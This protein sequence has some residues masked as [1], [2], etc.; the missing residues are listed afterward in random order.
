MVLEALR[1]DGLHTGGN[2][3]DQHGIGGIRRGRLERVPDRDDPAVDDLHQVDEQ[4]QQGRDGDNHDNA[5]NV[6][7]RPQVVLGGGHGQR[8]HRYPP[9]LARPRCRPPMMM[10]A[11]SIVVRSAPSGAVCFTASVSA[12]L[13][14]GA[15]LPIDRA[16][17]KIGTTSATTTSTMMMPMV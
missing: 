14:F 2:L 16:S 17:I 11:C 5:E 8:M 12:S 3:R 10:V 9:S 13:I 6:R 7:D 15:S 1:E 4:A